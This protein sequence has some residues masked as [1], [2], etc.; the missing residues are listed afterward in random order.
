MSIIIIR[1]GVCPLPLVCDLSRGAAAGYT[2]TGISSQPSHE[3]LQCVPSV[4]QLIAVCLM[5][6]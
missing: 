1:T 4:E 3:L 5:T 2:Q 6:A